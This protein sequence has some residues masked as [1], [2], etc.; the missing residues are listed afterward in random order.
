MV[1]RWKWE[2]KVAPRKVINN[3]G[4]VPFFISASVYSFVERA[5]LASAF[6]K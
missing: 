2:E 3:K 4:L 6:S 1:L 5:A